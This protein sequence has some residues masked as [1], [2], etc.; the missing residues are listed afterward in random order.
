MYERQDDVQL[1]M[2]AADLLIEDRYARRIAVELIDNALKFSAAGDRVTVEGRREAGRYRLR[3]ADHRRGMD[4]DHLHR[5]E[6]F[7][8]VDRSTHEQQSVGLGL[9][10]VHRIVQHSGADV[11]ITSEE[12]KGTTVN[13][14]LPAVSSGPGERAA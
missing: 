13:V 6:A 12:G 11:Q 5:L 3:V 2:E 4:E 10:L 9:A 7:V 1:D 14:V 8:Q